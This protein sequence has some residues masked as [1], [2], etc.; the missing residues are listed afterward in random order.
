MKIALITIGK[1]NEKYLDDGMAIYLKR[2]KHYCH[3][4]VLELKD[5]KAFSSNEDLKKAEA[6][7]ILTKL[8]ID[9]CLVL[10]DEHG[11]EVT[12][13]A[14]AQFIE[15]RSMDSGRRI[16]FLVGGAFGVADLI[17]EKSEYQLSLSQMTFSHQM[18]RLFFVEQL[19]RAFTIIKNEKYHN[20]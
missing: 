5:V 17:K 14:F 1:T 19:Y 9:D 4:E 7:L 11:K 12:S 2:L 18:I 10:L 13:R 15:K 16:V 8:K 6:E 3:F 20:D